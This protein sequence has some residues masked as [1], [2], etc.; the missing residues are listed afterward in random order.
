MGSWRLGWCV[1]PRLGGQILGITLL[2]LGFGPFTLLKNVFVMLTNTYENPWGPALVSQKVALR[3]SLCSP[4]GPLNGSISVPS[5]TYVHPHIFDI[6]KKLWGY[7]WDFS[8][9][10]NAQI[11]AQKIVQKL[12]GQGFAPLS[13]QTLWK[14]FPNFSVIFGVG[15]GLFFGCCG[16]AWPTFCPKNGLYWAFCVPTSLGNLFGYFGLFCPMCAYLHDI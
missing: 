8:A 2:P 12:W 3:G 6:H 10:K 5:C 1:L 14:Y 16:P 11:L 13:A 9:P 4:L 15:F 7:V